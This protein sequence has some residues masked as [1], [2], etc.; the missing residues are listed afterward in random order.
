MSDL[1]DKLS[2][3]FLRQA[4]AS[5][6]TQKSG[7]D[8]L[9]E[10]VMLYGARVLQALAEAPGGID[11]VHHIVRKTDISIGDVLQVVTALSEKG[12]VEVRQEDK[13]GDHEIALTDRGRKA[14]G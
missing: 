4:P 6:A 11:G 5:E 1:R 3:G 9:A 8:F 13:L 14:I 12:Y 10:A 7:A 2:I